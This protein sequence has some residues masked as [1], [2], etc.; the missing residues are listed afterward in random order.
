MPV[1]VTPRTKRP[2]KRRSREETARYIASVSPQTSP[3][4]GD[5][6]VTDMEPFNP[7]DVHHD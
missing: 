2:S 3:P 6:S 4:V 5:V 1:D 7:V